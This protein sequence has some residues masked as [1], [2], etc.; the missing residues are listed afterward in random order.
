MLHVISY[1]IIKF[2]QAKMATVFQSDVWLQ[3]YVTLYIEKWFQA[4]KKLHLKLT[5]E[6]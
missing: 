5:R 6:K 3:P 2:A 1:N 4:V